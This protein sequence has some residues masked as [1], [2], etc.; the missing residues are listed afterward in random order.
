MSM[1]ASTA[2]DRRRMA[3][4][5]AAE[6]LLDA[7]RRVMACRATEDAEGEIEA[8]HEVNGWHGEFIVAVHRY[9]L[10]LAVS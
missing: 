7:T 3:V 8:I 5:V 4:G 1:L 2:L 6:G 9:C 10:T